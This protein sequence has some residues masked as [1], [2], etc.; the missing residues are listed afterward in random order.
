MR[1]PRRATAL[2]SGGS[3]CRFF[4]LRLGDFRILLEPSR[5]KDDVVLRGKI[6]TDEGVKFE[7]VGGLGRGAYYWDDRLQVFV[8]AS[9]VTM[10]VTR[11]Q[12]TEPPAKVREALITLAKQAIARLGR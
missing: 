12:F 3:D 2:P 9:S 6:L 8:G 5:E 1:A 4:G 7:R 11:S 10:W